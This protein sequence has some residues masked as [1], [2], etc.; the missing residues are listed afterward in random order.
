MIID[1]IRARGFQIVP[2]YQLLGKTRAEVMAPLPAGERWVARLDRL[3]FWLVN[4]AVTM[5][6]WNFF[7]GD[8]LI[9]GRLSFIWAVAVFHLLQD[10]LMD[11]PGEI[12]SYK[13]R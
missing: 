11:Q 4:T 8:L 6:T 12:A 2:V 13:P 5:I 3:G 7:L 1:G 9:T 10:L